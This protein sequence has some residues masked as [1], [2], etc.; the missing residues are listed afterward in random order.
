V[1]SFDRLD[2]ELIVTSIRR[3]VRDGSILALLRMF[4]ESGVML[5]GHW[6]AAEIGSPQGGVISP[7]ISNVYLD[8]FD[9][10]MKLEALVAAMRKLLTIINPLIK[11]NEWWVD[12]LAPQ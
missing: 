3:R 10:E 8:A 6:E 7:L 5:D 9:Q 1:V 2:H 12:R 4:L 11:N